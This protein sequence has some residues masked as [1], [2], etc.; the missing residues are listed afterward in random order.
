MYRT[1]LLNVNVL[2]PDADDALRG[3]YAPT[4]CAAYYAVSLSSVISVDYVP[5]LFVARSPCS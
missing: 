5:H 3:P 4:L 2:G 1:H